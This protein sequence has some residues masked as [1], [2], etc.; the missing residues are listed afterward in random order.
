MVKSVPPHWF[1]VKKTPQ[2][3]LLCWQLP[4]G[5]AAGTMT[6]LLKTKLQQRATM[7]IN[8]WSPLLSLILLQ[9]YTH[10]VFPLRKLFSLLTED[11]CGDTGGWKESTIQYSKMMTLIANKLFERIT[12]TLILF[13]L[14]V[15]FRI[16][17]MLKQRV[18]T[19]DSVYLWCE[20]A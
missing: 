19:R 5:N 10:I 18:S 20:H 12:F 15:I 11:S 6:Y 8:C 7:A 3:N 16:A 4:T 1:Q 9:T 2:Q 14:H 17:S 13:S